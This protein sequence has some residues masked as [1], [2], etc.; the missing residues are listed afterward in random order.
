[1]YTFHL[2]TMD[3][4]LMQKVLDPAVAVPAFT[5]VNDGTN[6]GLKYTG[7]EYLYRTVP[8]GSMPWTTGFRIP[9]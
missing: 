4:R 8:S 5:N 9:V 7:K 1:M 6:E 2:R 3:T